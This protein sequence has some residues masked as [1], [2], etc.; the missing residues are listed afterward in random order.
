MANM[1]GT[2][3]HTKHE[4]QNS[5]S[6]FIISIRGTLDINAAANYIKNTEFLAN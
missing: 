2:S 6:D 1:P 5:I 4:H 3:K